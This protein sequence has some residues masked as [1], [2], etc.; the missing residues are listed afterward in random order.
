MDLL[1]RAPESEDVINGHRN[2]H[3]LVDSLVASI[4][5]SEEYERRQPAPAH[6][7]IS[8]EQVVRAYNELLRRKPESEAVIDS[9]IAGHRSIEEL[10]AS[11]R[12]SQEFKNLQ[13]FSTK[14]KIHWDQVEAEVANIHRLLGEDPNGAY[15]RA[16]TD[17]WLEIPASTAH[18]ESEDYRRWVLETYSKI[19]S[20]E[21]Y[22]ASSE[23]TD[24]DLATYVRRPVPYSNGSSEAIGDML[25]AIGHVIR[26]MGLKPY[27]SILEFGFGWGNTTVQLAMSGYQ[28]MGIDIA[29]NFVEMVRRRTRALDLEVDLRVGSFFDAETIDQQ[30]DAVL[31]FECFHHCDDHIRLLKALPRL[32]KPGGKL[33]LAGETINNALPY[34]WGV[35][36]DSQ[37]IYCIRQFGWLELSF[38]ENYILD[39]L[40]R[41]RWI[42]EKH[43]FL[44]AMGVTYI[45]T[46]KP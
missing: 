33:V 22:S 17:F 2:T 9:Q 20:R 38:R 18:P 23:E 29:P 43:N 35:N 12:S 37:A 21:T 42:V 46:R 10:E 13:V 31:F 24:Y 14:R 15:Q 7:P 8:R 36:P 41:L 19:S 11:L 1:G 32:L 45:A 26:V 39:L 28:V 40:D 27:S 25:M 6:T 4:K 3:S 5:S 44:N 16:L 34:P 30:F